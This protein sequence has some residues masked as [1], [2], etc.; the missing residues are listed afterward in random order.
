M[1]N[2]T[3]APARAPRE[4]E[5]G[6]DYPACSRPGSVLH[7]VRTV[8]ATG[9]RAEFVTRVCAMHNR[10]LARSTATEHAKR[11]ALRKAASAL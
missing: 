6:C 1:T 5:P 2:K 3:P 11:K 9:R 8:D 4:R 10:P 7:S